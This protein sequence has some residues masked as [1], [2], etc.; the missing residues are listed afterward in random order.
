MKGMGIQLPC[1]ANEGGG[2]GRKGWLEYTRLLE[3]R[4]Q[5]L[6]SRLHGDRRQRMKKQTAGS[7]VRLTRVM[8]PAS[9]DGGGSEGAAHSNAPDPRKKRDG[10]VWTML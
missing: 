5:E 10:T 2:L 6:R 8:E 4:A 1:L 7:R 9:E 3:K